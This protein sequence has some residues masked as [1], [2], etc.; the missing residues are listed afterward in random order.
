MTIIGALDEFDK[1]EI[2]PTKAEKVTN[3][4]QHQPRAPKTGPT[5]SSSSTTTK[6]VESQPGLNFEDYSQVD[7]VLKKF[8]DEDPILK[9]HWEQMA[10]QCGK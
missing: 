1:Q 8:M 3:V 7:D 4:S 2:P 10:S 6:K 5:A 9:Q